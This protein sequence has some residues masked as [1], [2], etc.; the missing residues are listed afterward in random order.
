V[1]EPRVVVW[2][3]D[4]AAGN[5]ALVRRSL[6]AGFEAICDVVEHWSGEEAL[7]H[8]EIGFAGDPERLPDVIFMD[9]FL[10]DTYGNEVT[11]KIR[12]EF[13]AKK[14]AGPFIVGHSSSPPA[15]LEIVKC[16]GDVA[17]EKDRHAPFSPGVKSLFPDLDALKSYAGRARK[18]ATGTAGEP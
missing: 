3:V 2:V 8:V 16:G 10:G 11:K 5:H 9:F 7:L 1:S 12:A 14:L 6:P 18:P 15:S 4:D 17:I 13:A